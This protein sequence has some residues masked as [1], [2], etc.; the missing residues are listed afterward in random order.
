[1][2]VHLLFYNHIKDYHHMLFTTTSDPISY[3]ITQ[4][5]SCLFL[6]FWF[7]H[8]NQMHPLAGTHKTWTPNLDPQS[9]PQSGPPYGPQ[10]GPPSNGVNSFECSNV[11]IRINFSWNIWTT[12]AFVLCASSST[13]QKHGRCIGKLI[14]STVGYFFKSFSVSG[15]HPFRYFRMMWVLVQIW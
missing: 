10:Y 4:L 3:E 15:T 7:L 13:L 5:E 11:N 8:C 14:R 6:Y 2:F 12:R 9:G 1:M